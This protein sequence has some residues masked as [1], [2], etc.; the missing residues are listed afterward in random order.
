MFEAST[1]EKR[2]EVRIV[3]AK[4][5][6]N[7]FAEMEEQNEELK[8]IKSDQKDMIALFCEENEDYTPKQIKAGY[9]YFLKFVKDRSQ[10]TEDELEREKMIELIEQV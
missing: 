10:L 2:E 8:S 3:E 4:K 1:E 7:I 5:V 6:L 9:K